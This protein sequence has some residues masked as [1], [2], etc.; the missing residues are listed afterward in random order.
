MGKVYLT[1]FN[2]N[3]LFCHIFFVDVFLQSRLQKYKLT[4]V[5]AITSKQEGKGMITLLINIA[6]PQVGCKQ[7]R[8]CLTGGNQF[9]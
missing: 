1:D 9:I 4:A 3:V 5:I 8:L 7:R 2:S 6:K